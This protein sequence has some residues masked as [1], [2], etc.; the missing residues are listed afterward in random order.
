MAREDLILER[1]RSLTVEKQQQVLEFVDTLQTE[2]NNQT[3]IEQELKES[4][5]SRFRLEKP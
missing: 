4:R 5:F 2:A 3:N 1:R